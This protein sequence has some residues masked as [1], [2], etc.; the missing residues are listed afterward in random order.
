MQK[1]LTN[2][3]K[4]KI[5]KKYMSWLIIWL[6]WYLKTNQCNWLKNERKRKTIWSSQQMY[7]KHSTKCNI[8]SFLK[9][10]QKKKPLRRLWIKSDSH[11]NKEY[12]WKN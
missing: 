11:P 12:L 8:Y 7:E 1:L 6:V 5:Y 2:F 9:T 3:L 4:S 10:D